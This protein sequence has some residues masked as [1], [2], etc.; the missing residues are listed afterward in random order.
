MIEILEFAY[1]LLMYIVIITGCIAVPY[2]F[3]TAFLD[4][5]E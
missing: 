3:Y 5:N 4:D 1:L 2:M